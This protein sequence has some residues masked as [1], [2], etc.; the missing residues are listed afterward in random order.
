MK[1]KNV[2]Q[3]SSGTNLYLSGALFAIALATTSAGTF[4]AD[5]PVVEQKSLPVA[6]VETLNKLSGGPYA[7]YRAN[8][9]KGVVVEGQFEPAKTA[10]SLSKAPQF[11]A[12]ST[13]VIVRF[14][15]G[16]GL[17]TMPDADRHASPHGIAI[18]FNLP[19]GST[20]DIVSISANSFPVATP[21][22]F[23]AL[24]QAI[25]QSGPTTPKPTPVEKFLGSHPA[26]AKWVSTPRPAPVSFGTLAFYGIN[27][28][29]F[30]NAEGISQYAR[31]Q[32]VPVAGEQALSDADASKATP[33]YLMEELPTRIAQGPVKFRILAQLAKEGDPINDP[34]IAWPSDRIVVELG[35]LSLTTTVKDQV[36]IQKALL[37]NPVGLPDGIEPSDDPILLARFPT[38]AVSFG[39][40][41]K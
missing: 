6:L 29:K 27:A 23:L 25:S 19:D 41:A 34:S 5:V 13:P 35:T 15:N 18:R 3:P 39:Q 32:I 21:E 12:K 33:N 2:N 8:H 26:A 7:G 11:A 30:T 14:S 38:Y 1:S 37:F 17:P 22:D 28:F 24:L 36:N 20:T 9:A 31:Y 16:T 10:L 4:A 40:R